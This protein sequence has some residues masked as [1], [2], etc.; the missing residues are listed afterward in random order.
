MPAMGCSATTAL[1]SVTNPLDASSSGMTR[2][3]NHSGP[4]TLTRNSSSMT[5]SSVSTSGPNATTPAA[6]TSPSR[7][8]WRSV[9]AATSRSP[10]R[11]SRR[12]SSTHSAP[13][14][15]SV[16][17]RS[18]CGPARTTSAPRAASAAQIGRPRP[19]PAPTTATTRPA[20]S[21]G[22][23]S[24]VSLMSIPIV[25][26]TTLRRAPPHQPAPSGTRS[27]GHS[28]APGC[29]SSTAAAAPP[30]ASP[31]TTSTGSATATTWS[32]A[33]RTALRA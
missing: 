28:P 22:T 21:P 25:A 2:R 15:S 23:D 10:A 29:P 11:A 17:R 6:L 32:A 5:V 12:S 26:G 3:S 27:P 16:G 19:P 30:N 8:P 20:R 24:G 13:G 9:T 33:A 14:W 1:S 31:A 18:G 7:R 4:M